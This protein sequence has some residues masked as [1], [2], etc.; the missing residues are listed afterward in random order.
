MVL[1]SPSDAFS[2]SPSGF[3]ALVHSRLRPGGRPAPDPGSSDFELESAVP[4]LAE[5]AAAARPAAVLVPVLARPEVTL[6]FTQRTDHLP[7]HAGQIAFPGGKAEPFDADPLA[8]ALREANEEVGLDAALV[9]PLGVLDP[10][11]TGT[12]YNITPVIALVD[13]A[14]RLTPDANEVAD[15]FEVPLAFLMEPG[16]YQRH[17][18]TV[19]GRERHYHAI[20]FGPRFIWGATAGILYAMRRRLFAS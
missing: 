9:E 4:D 20:P 6:L 15:T 16:N 19:R 14:A 2:F 12:G 3:R 10:Y 7:A 11:L 13:P 8:T 5:L 1:S 17:V 18:R